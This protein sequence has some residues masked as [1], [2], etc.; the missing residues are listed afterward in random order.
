[1]TLEIATNGAE[2]GPPVRLAS[3]A[4]GRGLRCRCPNCGD[5]R[6]FTSYLKVADSCAVCGE[7]LHH[8][9]ADDAPPYVVITIVAHVVVTLLLWFELAYK[10]ELW[11]HFVL[12]IPLTIGLSLALLPPV[13]GALIGLQWALR[14]HGFGGA[15]D[16]AHLADA[17]A[18]RR[19]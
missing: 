11:V 17:R 18:E 6:S 4:M 13:K 15:T 14:M 16:D 10:P 19:A 9:R 12:W 2:A 7:E 5:G 3:R 1:M 8:Q